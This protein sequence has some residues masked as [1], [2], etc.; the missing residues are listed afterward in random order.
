MLIHQLC[1]L[2]RLRLSCSQTTK[3]GLTERSL[4]HSIY[5]GERLFVTHS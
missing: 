2:V 3:L 5:V 1:L 4:H